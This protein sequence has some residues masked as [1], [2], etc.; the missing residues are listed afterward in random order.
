MFDYFKKQKEGKRYWNIES[1][2][3]IKMQLESRLKIIQR[4]VSYSK[5]FGFYFK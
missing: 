3:D 1:K 4:Y 5:Y 2:N